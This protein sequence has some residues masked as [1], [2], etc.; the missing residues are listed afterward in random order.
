MKRIWAKVISKVLIRIFLKIHMK[1]SLLGEEGNMTKKLIVALILFSLFALI[2]FIGFSLKIE[3]I[4]GLKSKGFTYAVANNSGH[5]EFSYSIQLTNTNR[6]AVY[7]KTIE[8]LINE[9]MKKK[10]ISK[11]I[12]VTVNKAILPNETILVSGVIF[13]DT[14]DL[15]MYDIGKLVAEIKVSTEETI[16]LK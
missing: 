2:C 15:I 1:Y 12:V 4:G 7:I 10:I 5:S 14:K 3:T 11:D 6:K 13:V 8:P 16:S 9:T